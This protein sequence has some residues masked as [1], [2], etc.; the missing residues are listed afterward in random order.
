MAILPILKNP[1]ERLRIVAKPVE[2]IDDSIRQI[3]QDMLETMEVAGGVGL[4]ATQVDI[5]LKI[6]VM[7][8]SPTRNEPQIFINPHI[9]WTSEDKEVSYEGCLSVPD[10]RKIIKRHKEVKFTYL[11][12]NGQF[13]DMH[14]KGLLAVCIQHETDHLKGII[15]TDHLDSKGS[16]PETD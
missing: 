1:D 12:L 16:D 4:A 2:K 14:A 15:F 10:L 7:D 3:C 8:L 11:D 5:H 6:V 13:H 9:Y